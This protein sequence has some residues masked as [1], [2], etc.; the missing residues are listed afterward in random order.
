MGS[1]LTTGESTND[2]ANLANLNHPR[3]SSGT[4]LSSRSLTLSL[5]RR[6]RQRSSG[7]LNKCTDFVITTRAVTCCCKYGHAPAMIWAVVW[8]AAALACARC[9]P[10][11]AQLRPEDA[12]ASPQDNNTRHGG[13][14]A[15]GLRSDEG[16]KMASSS[17]YFLSHTILLSKRV[18]NSLYPKAKALCD[19]G[20]P[21]SV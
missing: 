9:G 4:A 19:Q 21:L 1:F 14:Q 18:P 11:A 8:W 16:P 20:P 3:R 7:A 12:P 15:R 2:W 10:A 6:W 5:L 17:F 13:A